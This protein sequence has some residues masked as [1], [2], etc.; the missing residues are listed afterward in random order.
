MMSDATGKPQAL[1]DEPEK[2][3]RLLD[4]ELV[5]KRALWKEA[6]ARH[7]IFRK[8]GFFSIFII[9]A[10]VFLV[11]FF[12]FARV[13]EERSNPQPATTSNA[14]GQRPERAP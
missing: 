12:L 5:Q 3:I 9:L 2:L 8:I 4:L 10:A 7:R 1:E 11:L 6:A 14:A 13:S